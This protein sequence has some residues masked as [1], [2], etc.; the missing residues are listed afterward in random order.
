MKAF[1]VA[2]L[3]GTAFAGFAVQ[4]QPNFQMLDKIAA[5]QPKVA[6]VSKAVS[7]ELDA[8]PD[9]SLEIL[10]AALGKVTPDWSSDEVMSLLKT[11]F[12]NM[13]VEQIHFLIPEVKTLVASYHDQFGDSVADQVLGHL[14][15]LALPVA[16]AVMQQRAA[17]AGQTRQEVPVSP[18]VVPA[19]PD[20]VST[21]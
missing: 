16:N 13:P 2:V 18:V 20:D 1:A 9:H 11:A 10:K 15:Q 14:D 4:A 6:D 5:A 8:Y 7:D 21:N 17:A 19:T 3:L 12:A